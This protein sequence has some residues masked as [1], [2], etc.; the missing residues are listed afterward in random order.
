MRISVFGMGFIGSVTAICLAELGHQI[1]ATDINQKLLATLKR[2]ENPFNEPKFG[3]LL[4]KHLANGNIVFSEDAGQ[5]IRMSDCSFIVVNT[6]SASDGSV[7]LDALYACVNSVVDLIR[8]EKP[9]EEHLL[10]LKSTTP[11]GTTAALEARYD[12]DK[13]TFA[14]NPD[15][16]R[17]GKA[18][19]D[20]LTPEAIV[21]GTND[22]SIRDKVFD[23][24]PNQN[25]EYVMT[26]T[27]TAELVKYTNNAFHA[28]K[29]AFANEIGRVAAA[30]SVNANVVMNTLCQDTRLNISKAY[31]K[32]GFA[33]GGSC[34]PKD[35]KGLMR[36]GS[37]Q[38][39]GTP[40][41][42]AVLK[43]NHRHIDFSAK[44]IME[45][46]VQ[47]IGFVGLAFKKDVLDMRESPIIYLMRTLV[48]YG[49]RVRFF[50]ADLEKMLRIP[51]NFSFINTVLPNW[52]NYCV[53]S[54]DTLHDVCGKILSRN[55]LDDLI[56]QT[57]IQQEVKSQNA[58]LSDVR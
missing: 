22:A 42:H 52:E 37:E 15:F 9:Q 34:L 46:D 33:F 56:V 31:L 55:D 41:L 18:I 45:E 44:K 43:S 5:M 47:S 26:D 8:S 11:I 1:F 2:G 57:N 32:P 24:Y 58:L 25:A 54:E 36:M 53:E 29:I 20:F 30:Y 50:D 28:L 3:E 35:L 21:W 49:K 6:P 19:Q 7:N 14:A 51:S 4:K 39:V 38:Q 48:E 12:D 10:V 16:T 17:E 27:N 23:I 40:L 13:I